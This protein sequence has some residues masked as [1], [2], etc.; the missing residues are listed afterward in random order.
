MQFDTNRIRRVA[1]TMAQAQCRHSCGS[2][3]TVS[4]VDYF[5]SNITILHS[6]FPTFSIA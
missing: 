3:D 2:P 1:H 4:G 6:D 5:D